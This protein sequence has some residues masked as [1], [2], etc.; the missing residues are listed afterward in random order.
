MISSAK[1]EPL[2]HLKFPLFEQRTRRR[3]DQNPMSEPASDQFGEHQ[4]GLDRLTQTHG[5]GQQQPHATAAQSTKD[6]NKLV[7]L[8][9]Q[10]PGLHRE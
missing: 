1:S 5:I 8:N 7:R 6:R 4:A 10:P 3:D 9:S 2:Q